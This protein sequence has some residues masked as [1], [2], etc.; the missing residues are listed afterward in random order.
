MV[1]R[2]TN[3]LVESSLWVS[4]H[5]T[6]FG[7]WVSIAAGRTI[8][9]VELTALFIYLLQIYTLDRYLDHPEDHG[10][11]AERPNP[12]AF[13]ARH[14]GAFRAALIASAAIDVLLVAI[15]PALLFRMAFCFALTAFYMVRVPW[16]GLRLKEVP[17][18]KNV[19]APGA[20]LAVF[21]AFLG[22]VPSWQDAP[23]LAMAY[24]LMQLNTILFDMKDVENDRRAGIRLIST[25]FAPDTVYALLTGCALAGALV[26]SIALPAP[27]NIGAIAGFLTTG[28]WVRRLARRFSRRLLFVWVDT[29]DIPLL[30]TLALSSIG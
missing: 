13:V 25:V 16:I 27:W 9:I 21:C 8:D 29:Q 14:R 28:V 10:A 2:A 22:I 20:L 5:T 12:A 17:F 24:L 4:L 18:F 3:F 11:P 6:A 19:Y 30:V 1:S 26:F 15:K 23:V 7:A